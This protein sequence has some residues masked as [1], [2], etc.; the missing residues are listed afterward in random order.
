M[1]YSGADQARASRE[2]LGK[3]LEALQQDPNIPD[4][5]M[6]VAQNIAQAVGALFEAEKASSEP[7]GKASVKAALGNLSQTLALLQDVKSTHG[8]VDVAT[9][10]IAQTMSK[11]YPLTTVPSRM[12]P[13]PTGD[14]TIKDPVVP[15]AAK[16]PSEAPAPIDPARASMP[17][18][19]PK[20]TGAREKIEANI[21]ATT[22]SN[23]YVGFSGE[24]SQGGVFLA[25]YEVL[26]KDSSVNVLVTLP[27]NF[28]FRCDGWVRFVRDPFDLSAD[29]GAD[30]G[31]GIQFENLPADARELVLR[32]IRKRPPMFYDD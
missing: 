16:V 30:P 25:T 9:Q 7:D 19:A 11:L 27:G 23:F 31:M 20:P 10:T 13:A 8:G 22:E 5:V 28:E 17:K 6:A 32:F 4:D 1:T 3:A 18:I 21:G 14:T 2:E 12:A 24:I 29:D 26:P 15:K